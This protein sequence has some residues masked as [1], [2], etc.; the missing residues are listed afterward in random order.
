M[1]TTLGAMPASGNQFGLTAPPCEERLVALDRSA[2]QT[3]STKATTTGVM[4]TAG[5]I[6][7][8][9]AAIETRRSCGFMASLDVA[10]VAID[11]GPMM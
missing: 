10:A 1:T 2:V 3:S 6:N 11:G 9:L 4:L 7:N 5:V 8:S